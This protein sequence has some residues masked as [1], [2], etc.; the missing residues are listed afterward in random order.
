MFPW[1]NLI[2]IMRDVDGCAWFLWDFP[3]IIAG[4]GIQMT[5]SDVVH[6]LFIH[7]PFLLV[8]MASLFLDSGC[9][10]WGKGCAFTHWSSLVSATIVAID[11]AEI[12]FSVRATCIYR[13]TR[14]ARFSSAQIASAYITLVSMTKG[15]GYCADPN[16]LCS[17]EILHT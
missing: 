9:A 2:L 5:Y 1:Q 6:I 8:N 12:Q 11:R 16:W 7:V 4:H 17:A 10:T 15:Y 3:C 13:C 14:L